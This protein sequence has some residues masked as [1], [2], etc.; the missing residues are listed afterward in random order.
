MRVEA[1]KKYYLLRHAIRALLEVSVC[2][3]IRWT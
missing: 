2:L 1:E 3:R